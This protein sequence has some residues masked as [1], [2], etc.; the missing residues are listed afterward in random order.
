MITIKIEPT[1]I[2]IKGTIEEESELYLLA[3]YLDPTWK[4]SVY[5]LPDSEGKYLFLPIAHP[6]GL[7]GLVEVKIGTYVSLK[8]EKS[9]RAE[10]EAITRLSVELEKEF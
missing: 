6:F 7:Q 1:H 5:E 8:V 3:D 9:T 10:I 2:E 4:D